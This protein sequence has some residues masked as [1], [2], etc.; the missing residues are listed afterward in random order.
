[1]RCYLAIITHISI[2]AVKLVRNNSNNNIIVASAYVMS[3][4]AEVNDVRQS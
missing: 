2:I 3:N 4:A 1:M